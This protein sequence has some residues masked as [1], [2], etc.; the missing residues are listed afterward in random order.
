MSYILDALKKS[1][2][3]RTLVRGVGFGDA[4]RRLTARTGGA[5]WIAGLT[6]VVIVVVAALCTVVYVR[7]SSTAPATASD[8]VPPVTDKSDPA[9]SKRTVAMAEAKPLPPLV[10]A[11]AAV[12]PVVALLPAV[13]EARPLSAMSS[14]FQRSLPEMTVNIHV[15]S[16]EDTQQI[17]Y[18]NNRQY[19]RGDE[20]T[21][22]VMVEDI[23]PDG[24]VLQFRG[25][26]FKM[27]RPS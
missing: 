7:S 6:G 5:W 17:L 9:D 3:E 12:A 24:V 8:T 27:P 20:V 10:E 16:T 21:G 2:R 14:E 26:R 22:G 19:R 25:Q 23:V 1:E 13:G 4:G 18:I 11:K 15:Y